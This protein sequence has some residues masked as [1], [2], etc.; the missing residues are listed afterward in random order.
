MSREQIHVLI[1]DD[2]DLFCRTL[3]DSLGRNQ[4]LSFVVETATTEAAARQIVNVAARPFDVFLIDQRL[5]PGKDGIA[6]LRELRQLSPTTEAIIFTGVDDTD[7][8]LRAYQAGAHRYLIKPFDTHELV[9]ILRSLRKWRDTQYERDWLEVL[10]AVAQDAQRALSV[11]E[12]AAI[13]VQGGQRLGFE[14][15]RL[16][17][18]SE[19]QE[20]L[21]GASQVGHDEL[22]DFVSFPMPISESTYAQLALWK[23]EPSFFQ[24]QEHGEGYMERRVGDQ[25]FK[26]PIGE[27]LMLPLWAAERCLGVL[28]LDNASQ[29]RPLR[30]EQRRLLDLFGRQVAA[31]L[32]RA[33]LYELEARKSKGLEVLNEIGRRVT[34]SAAQANLDQL[35]REV[36]T[37]VGQFMD[38]DNFKVVLLNRE[39]GQL[40]FRLHVEKGQIKQRY[41]WRRLT[42]LVWHLISRNAPLL[43]PDGDERY[44]EEHS[45]RRLGSRSRSWLGVPLRVADVAEGCIV[46]WNRKR[47]HAYDDDDQRVLMA[48]ADQVAGVIQTAL[49][50][51]R[52]E[53]N[54]RQLAMLNRASAE[55]MRLAEENEN[56]LWHMILTTATA[57]YALGF[58]RAILLLAEQGG[59]YLRGRLGIGHFEISKAHRA[60]REEQDRGF[61]SYLHQLRDNQLKPTPVEEFVR[62]GWVL[63][64][65]DDAG[66]LRLAVSE[67]KRTLVPAAQAAQLLPAAFVERFGVTNYALLPLRAGSK[68]LGLVVVDNIHNK[69][70]LRDTALHHLETLLTQ[71]AL[72]WEALRQRRARDKLID[73]NHVVMAELSNR[74]LKE[75]LTQVCQVAQAVLG[76]DSVTIYVLKPEREPYEFDTHNTTAIGLKTNAYL[77]NV[78]RPKGISSHILRAGPLV[79]PDI[80]EDNVQYD[81]QRLA[82]NPFHQAEHFR[83]II[84]LPLRDRSTSTPLGVMYL[85][86]RTPRAVSD[87]DIRQAESFASL[88]ALAIRNTWAAQRTHHALATVEA[89]RQDRERE[90]DTLRRVLAESLAA[91]T[92]EEKVIRALLN[93]AQELLG[94]PGA[95]V[96]LQLLEWE[97]SD[98][99]AGKP[100]EVRSHYFRN[101]DVRLIA[102]IEPGP[103]HGI[104][105]AALHSRQI[106][107]IESVDLAEWVPH[108]DETVSRSQLAMPITLG[109]QVIGIFDITSASAEAFTPVHARMLERLA[110]AAALALDNVRR[111]KHL[112][113]VLKA[114]QTVMTPL[115][116][117]ETLNAVLE[118]MRETT[119]GLSALTIWYREPESGRIVLGSYFGIRHEGGMRR[120]EPS[121]HSVVR[122]VMN[123]SEPLWAPAAKEEPLLTSP[124]GRFV[125]AEN[126][127][128][129]AAF[130][131]RANDEIV[132]AIFLNYRQRHNFT[133]EE[134]A[135][136]PILAAI[137]AASVRDAARLETIRKDRDRLE[138]VIAITRTIG[139]VLGLDDTL[140]KIME[141]LQR[142]FPTATPCVLTY[143]EAGPALDFIQA[144]L[145]F[146]TIDN[147]DHQGL[148]RVKLDSPG[149][150][151]RVARQALKSKDVEV[152]NVGDVDVDK[153]YLRLLMDTRSELCVTAMS[154]GQLLGVIVLESTQPNAFHEGDLQLARHVARQVGIAIDRARASAQLRFQTSVAIATAWAAEIVHEINGQVGLIRNRISWINNDPGLSQQSRHYLREIEAFA[155]ELV[156]TL[157]SSEPQH[158]SEPEDFAL[159]EQVEQW[160]HQMVAERRTD[161]SVQVTSGGGPIQ[162]RGYRLAL[163]WALRHLV[164]NALEAME[165][166]GTLLVRISRCEEDRV[167]IQIEDTGPGVP[168]HLRQSILCEPASSHGQERGYGLLL[169]RKHIENMG[170]GIRLLPSPTGQGA[171]FA[172]TLPLRL[173]GEREVRK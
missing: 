9:W 118:A 98:Q 125:V 164:R 124:E 129:T 37:Q 103:Y 171:I 66:A 40:D 97:K 109:A 17:L 20:T 86:S 61:E 163:Q 30:P 4:E 131:L 104:T 59:T 132:G 1:L 160:V 102:H 119:P 38:V 127:E 141:E 167:E 121:A 31:A 173:G 52:E 147:P 74:P 13:V 8:G 85:N 39:T 126:I 120:E 46:V 79:V 172:M 134:R 140:H 35:L 93:A 56:W 70:P 165:Q 54:R 43:L 99:P 83:A 130:P 157:S 87:Q 111:Q 77:R 22:D 91:D 16:W 27:W 139:T 6:V 64:L 152:A 24:G 47:E 161:I 112:Y 45:I 96:G 32:E 80:I 49:L 114:A 7:A 68:V 72:T 41:C 19:N 105:G 10:T 169:V 137:A 11:H 14:R 65:N 82:D 162:F 88:A 166:P 58:N 110:A 136:F 90:L 116:L 25:G 113:T 156:G 143:D 89:E 146:Y 33:R 117:H 62:Q 5:G 159:D 142:L 168:E 60:W 107:L 153:S 145:E 101:T 149:I 34:A 94:Q 123:L 144:S 2:D 57:E 67:G 151:C 106:Q 12:V 44:I 148:T 28:T 53:Q 108:Y 138:R 73:L 170:G 150:A 69:E 51:E 158:R 100:P 84:G 29:D 23:R 42:G 95:Q 81:G 21:I 71:A 78:P 15:A 154:G 63:D 3:A 155:N 50:K 75:T 26:P 135:L 115:G 76:S 18:L 92:G 36:H 122:T 55:M 133:V 128:S 48:V